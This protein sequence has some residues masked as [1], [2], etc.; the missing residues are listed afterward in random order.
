MQHLWVSGAVRPLKWP[1]DFKWLILSYHLRLGLPSGLVIPG[2]PPTKTPYAP[3]VSSTRAT[4]P[5]HLI[6]L[7]FYHPHNIC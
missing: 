1:L 6:L 2:L 5:A 7:D 4:C 3:L